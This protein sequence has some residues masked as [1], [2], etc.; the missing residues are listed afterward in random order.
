MERAF[1]TA[2]TGTA[3]QV[4]L[5]EFKNRKGRET[6]AFNLNVGVLNKFDPTFEAIGMNARNAAILE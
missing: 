2:P 4:Q 1:L 6:P 5:P 3:R